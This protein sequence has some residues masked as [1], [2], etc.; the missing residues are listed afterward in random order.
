MFHWAETQRPGQRIDRGQRG[1]TCRPCSSLMY[2]STPMS[3]SSATSSRRR[4]EPFA[5]R[6]QEITQL[7]PAHVHQLVVGARNQ[8]LK[9]SQGDTR[10]G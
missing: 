8:E 10:S 9:P 6:T 1:V 5:P 7:G 2:Q 3:A 4:P